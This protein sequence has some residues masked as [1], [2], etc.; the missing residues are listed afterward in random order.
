M[1]Y[2]LFER[3]QAVDLSDE[4]FL[5][6]LVEAGSSLEFGQARDF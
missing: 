6:R 1:V 3:T 2:F 5:F 4:G